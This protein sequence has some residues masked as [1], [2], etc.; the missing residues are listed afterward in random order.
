MPSCPPLYDPLALSDSEQAGK[1]PLE[2]SGLFQIGDRLRAHAAAHR[3]REA[4]AVATA[5]APAAASAPAPALAPVP[6][7]AS[8]R[9]CAAPTSAGQRAEYEEDDFAVFAAAAAGADYMP[10]E[11][12][13][14]RA[15]HDRSRAPDAKV[16]GGSAAR[17]TVMAPPHAVEPEECARERGKAPEPVA[18]AKGSLR[19]PG[20][21][22]AEEAATVRAGLGLGKRS[23]EKKSR[24]N[25]STSASRSGSSNRDGDDG[26]NSVS[27]SSSSGK[28]RQRRRRRARR[29]ESPL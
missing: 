19:R 3:S 10:L 16:A 15:D 27:S 2:V 1:T 28:R 13:G 8:A 14:A 25:R 6:P 9:V 5:E 20:E 11:G 21:V 17:T 4:A 7:A 29:G 22:S 24:R 12:S 18:E 26:S 23:R